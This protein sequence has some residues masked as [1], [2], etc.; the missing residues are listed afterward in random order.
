[1][2]H[3]TFSHFAI[4]HITL[5]LKNIF[6]I[7][8]EFSI[9]NLIS[10]CLNQV[11]E[12]SVARDIGVWIWIK[13]SKNGKMFPKNFGCWGLAELRNKLS[14]D[15]VETIVSE[16]CSPYSSWVSTL[17]WRRVDGAST[18]LSWRWGRSGSRG[19]GGGWGI[20]RTGQGGWQSTAWRLWVELAFGFNQYLRRNVFILENGW[21]WKYVIKFWN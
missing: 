3:P 2:S 20:G 8:F 18:A 21:Q 6:I 4:I 10:G 13:F 16:F 9:E 17:V 15:M 7:I 14:E 5:L 1:M 11:Q 12:M 19:C